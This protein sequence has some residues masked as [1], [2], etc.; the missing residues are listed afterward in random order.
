VTLWIVGLLT[1]LAL[2]AV[3]SAED[4]V[5]IDPGS[6]AGKE[7][8]IPLAAARHQSGGASSGRSSPDDPGPL[9]GQGISRAPTRKPGATKRGSTGHRP[10]SARGDAT[11]GETP[12]DVELV[13]SSAAPASAP[14]WTLAL[15]L[16]VVL[17]GL[18]G[19]S[20]LRRLRR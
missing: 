9:F 11:A 6:P 20:G 19:G 8:A 7:Y 13:R 5:F 17:V 12:T 14:G 4:G 16:G 1:V 3:A 2:P 15:G 18:L 10:S